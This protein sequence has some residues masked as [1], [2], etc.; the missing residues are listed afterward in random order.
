[1][2]KDITVEDVLNVYNTFGD[3]Q[4]QRIYSGKVLYRG[5][6]KFTPRNVES[7][8]VM[9]IAFMDDKVLLIEVI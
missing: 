3:V 6:S 7:R 1:M 2:A 9:E 4:I 8:E 5:T